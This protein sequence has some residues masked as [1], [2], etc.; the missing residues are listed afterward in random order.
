[1][2]FAGNNEFIT[3]DLDLYKRNGDRINYDNTNTVDWIGGFLQGE[4][5]MDQL[6]FYGTFGYSM[7]KYDFVDHFKKGP[8][9]GE[10]QIA[11]DWINGYQAKGG[12]SFRVTPETDVYANFG[13]V[14]KVPIFDQVIDDVN[15]VKIDDPLN[16][17][18]LS[19]EAGANFNLMQNRLQV[20]TNVYFTNWT[21]RGQ[22]QGVQNA[23]GSE[24][25]VRLNGID[26]THMGVEAE[27]MYQP[28][29]SLIFDAAISKGIWEYGSDVSGSYIPDPNDPSSVENYN[30][31]ID[32]LKVGDQPQFQVFAGLTVIPIQGLRAQLVWN[33]NSEYYSLYDPFS[34]TR[35]DREQVWQIPDFHLFD[36]HLAYEI[37]TDFADV[38]VFGHVFNLFDELYVSD[39]TDASQ[40]NGYYGNNTDL[41]GDGD[42]DNLD[43]NHSADDAEIFPGLPR[44]FKAGFSIRF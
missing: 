15:S 24:G 18:F 25:L 16:E 3:N 32:G 20:K 12:L 4:Y 39:A 29:R 30:Y 11:T 13:Y 2:E 21:D 14:S 41:N 6:T 7:I 26:A 37:P 17:K 1:M 19:G 31:Y 9:G 44:N 23:D 10:R 22:S 42:I 36:F 35:A 28:C 33:F 34:R 5:T 8:D 43:S 38:T 27:I 40:Y